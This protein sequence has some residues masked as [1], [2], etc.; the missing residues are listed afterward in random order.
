MGK[1][2]ARTGRYQTPVIDAIDRLG[3]DRI[4]AGCGQAAAELADTV[5]R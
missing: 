4:D 5:W 2:L 1:F 3:L